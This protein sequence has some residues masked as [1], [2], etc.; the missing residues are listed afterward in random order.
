MKPPGLQEQ[1]FNI[2]RNT[3]TPVTFYL[4]NG[5]R[6]KGILEAFDA[7]SLMIRCGADQELVFKHAVSTVIPAWPLQM[8]WQQGADEKST[9]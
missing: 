2:L 7:Y 4:V 6:M 8:N 9:Q 3:R 1:F 5:F